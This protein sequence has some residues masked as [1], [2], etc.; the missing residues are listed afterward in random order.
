[1]K[2]ISKTTVIRHLRVGA[3]TL[4]LLCCNA[5]V[6]FQKNLDSGKVKSYITEED[7]RKLESAALRY[8]NIKATR[9]QVDDDLL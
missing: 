3:K 8:K 5:C 7:F 4:N 9:K 6:F 1:M 2:K